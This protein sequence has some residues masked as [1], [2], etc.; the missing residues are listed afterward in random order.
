[1]SA[2]P[3]GPPLPATDHIHQVPRTINGINDGLP[4]EK[5]AI[6]LEQVMAAEVG[7][8]LDEVVFVWWGQAVMAQDPDRQRRLADAWAGR[9]LV[10]LSEIQRRLELRDD[11]G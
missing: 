10:P 7:P 6:F 2:E 9:N 3:L 11:V 5:R 8:D 1:M 4:E